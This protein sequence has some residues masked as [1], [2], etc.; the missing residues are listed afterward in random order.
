MEYWSNGEKETFE[1]S[2]TPLLQYS[3]TPSFLEK[4]THFCPEDHNELE[5]QFP[6]ISPEKYSPQPVTS[7]TQRLY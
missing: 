4:M 7:S 1:S 3:N 2:N 5:C 6:Q